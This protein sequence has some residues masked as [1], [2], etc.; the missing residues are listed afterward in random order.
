[1]PLAAGVLPD[2][3]LIVSVPPGPT[4]APARPVP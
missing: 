1:M 3:L 2:P 4:L